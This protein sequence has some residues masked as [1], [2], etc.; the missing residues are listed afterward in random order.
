ML[1]LFDSKKPVPEKVE[2]LAIYKGTL[3]DLILLTRNDRTV[4]AKFLSDNESAFQMEDRAREISE[5][6][7]WG[8]KLQLGVAYYA[9]DVSPAYLA[10]CLNCDAKHFL[11]LKYIVVTENEKWAS[12]WG[13]PQPVPKEVQ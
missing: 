13:A 10:H 6:E 2:S 11:P 12:L 4:R 9:P 8:P 3:K 5:A 7:G 1:S